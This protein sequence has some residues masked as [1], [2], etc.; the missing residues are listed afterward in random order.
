VRV[1]KYLTQELFLCVPYQKRLC[2]SFFVENFGYD[3]FYL[4][5]METYSKLCKAY[6][7]PYSLSRLNPIVHYVDDAVGRYGI[8]TVQY[9][10]TNRYSN[11][12]ILYRRFC[13]IEIGSIF[14][15]S[16]R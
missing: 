9:T 4:V 5:Y 13:A 12:A 1:F 11:F 3:I 15:G 6:Q 8:T 2:M 16:V 14:R 7:P 10:E